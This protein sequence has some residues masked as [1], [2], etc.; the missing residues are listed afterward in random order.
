VVKNASKLNK[1]VHNVPASIEIKIARLKL[2][3][4][5][6]S[7]DKLSPEQKKYLASWEIGT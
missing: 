4:L 3:A 7:I 5:G 1:A 6:V 2:K